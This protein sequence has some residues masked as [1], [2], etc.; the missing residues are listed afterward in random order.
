MILFPHGNGKLVHDT[1]VD[2]VKLILGILP[3][4]RQ[5]LITHIKPK[6]VP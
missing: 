1:A 2:A 4:E 5:I 6:E 3:D